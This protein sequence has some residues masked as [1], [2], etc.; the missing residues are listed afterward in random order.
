[1]N[2]IIKNNSDNKKVIL[3]NIENINYSLSSTSAKDNNFD[4]EKLALT[5]ITNKLK[6][7]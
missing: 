3:W 4:I 7:D 6:I 5:L 2:I 1:M